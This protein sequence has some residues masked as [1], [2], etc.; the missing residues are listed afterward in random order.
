M[1][2]KKKKKKTGAQARLFLVFGCLTAAALLASTVL[3]LVGM[4]PTLVAMI[5]DRTKKGTLVLTVGAMNLAG[6]SPFLI[7]LWAKGHTVDIAV[8]LITEPLTIVVMYCAAGVGYIIDWAMSGIVGTVM[9]QRAEQRVED[10]NK[11]QADVIERW[12]REVTG[13][14]P[15]DPYGFP[16]QQET[17]ETE[18]SKED[19]QKQEVK[20]Q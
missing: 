13:E 19:Q 6:C 9:V 10:I 17:E 15:V 11:T 7:E 1:A 12:G 3:L 18:Q 8:S 20:D 5:A 4:L 16:I 14:I 2:A